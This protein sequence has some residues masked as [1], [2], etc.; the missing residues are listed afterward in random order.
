MIDR[1]RHRLCRPEKR[2]SFL[3]SFIPLPKV[4][5]CHV[6]LM[7]F[8]PLLGANQHCWL[9]KNPTPL[10]TLK[11]IEF[12]QTC[13]ICLLS[14]CLS[15]SDQSRSG[16]QCS[17]RRRTFLPVTGILYRHLQGRGNL[18]R[19]RL[20]Q[21]EVSAYTQITPRGQWP[22]TRRSIGLWKGLGSTHFKSL[23]FMKFRYCVGLL[24]FA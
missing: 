12:R 10:I 5:K 21:V 1:R 16:E 2:S 11:R 6:S 24:T 9:E 18:T 15:L 4:E 17:A 14:H 23:L 19:D 8:W 20:P 3:P 22:Y 13:K 7:K